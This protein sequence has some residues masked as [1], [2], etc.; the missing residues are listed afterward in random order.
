MGSV[1]RVLKSPPLGVLRCAAHF[2]QTF[3]PK[4][5]ALDTAVMCQSGAFILTFLDKWFRRDRKIF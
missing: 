1:K 2:V 4:N 5:D 3:L